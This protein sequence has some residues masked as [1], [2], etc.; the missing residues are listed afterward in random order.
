MATF[1]TSPA[2]TTPQPGLRRAEWEPPDKAQEMTFH[3]L[4]VP[5]ARLPHFEGTRHLIISPFCTPAS[6]GA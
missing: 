6:N 4:G 2:R 3:A 1:L 5:G